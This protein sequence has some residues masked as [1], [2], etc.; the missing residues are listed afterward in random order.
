MHDG[1]GQLGSALTE[2]LDI[3]TGDR[4]PVQANLPADATGAVTQIAAG[5]VHSLALTWR[6]RSVAPAF[7]VLR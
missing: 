2:E 5:H 4:A 3:E 7:V 6:S 1:F